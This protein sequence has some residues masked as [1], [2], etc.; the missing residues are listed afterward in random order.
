[1]TTKMTVRIPLIATV[2]LNLEPQPEGGYTV[3]SPLVPGMVT[4]GD[5]VEECLA[6]AQDCFDLMLEIYEDE[7]KAFPEGMIVVDMDKPVI[8]AETAD[9]DEAEALVADS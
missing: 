9:T 8:P 7:D 6:M 2:P 3:T 4:E 1:M 5:T